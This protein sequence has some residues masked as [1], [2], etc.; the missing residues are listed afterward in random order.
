MSLLCRLTGGAGGVVSEGG[1]GGH[2]GAENEGPSPDACGGRPRKGP[3]DD[4]SAGVGSDPEGRSLLGRSVQRAV[5]HGG[6]AAQASGQNQEQR[7]AR[8]WQRIA[9]QL[10]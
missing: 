8:P 3:T 2:A 9:P 5:V 1:D 7:Q 6:V 4:V 10:P